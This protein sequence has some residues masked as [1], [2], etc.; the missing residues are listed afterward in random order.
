MIILLEEVD[1]YSLLINEH[2][3][4]MESCACRDVHRVKRI[5]IS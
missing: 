2:T 5:A 1:V 3:C 4:E